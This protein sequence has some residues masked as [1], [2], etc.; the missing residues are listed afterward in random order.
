MCM[1]IFCAVVLII[2]QSTFYNLQSTPHSSQSTAYVQVT[3]SASVKRSGLTLAGVARQFVRVP[4]LQGGRVYDLQW[5]SIGDSVLVLGAVV[6]LTTLGLQYQL[7][8]ELTIGSRV[9]PAPPLTSKWQH[10]EVRGGV[11]FNMGNSNKVNGN[12]VNV[13]FGDKTNVDKLLCNQMIGNNSS[14]VKP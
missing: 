11:G 10:L 3:I 8:N 14:V 4:G 1:C 13:V 5:N 12:K 2:L 7:L 6:H 9:M